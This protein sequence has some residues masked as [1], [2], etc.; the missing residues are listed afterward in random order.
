MANDTSAGNKSGSPSDESTRKQLALAR[1]QGDA[2]GKAVE[3][4]TQEEA[5]GEQV[6]TDDYLVGYAVEEAEGM[7][8]FRD[9]ALE[10]Q[11]PDDENAHIEIVVRDAHDGRFLPGLAVNVTVND[12]SGTVI[13]SHEQP[14]L[15]HPWL[16]HYG[17]NWKL[18]GD[19]TYKLAVH[20]EPPQYMRHDKVNGKRFAE[21][22]DVEFEGV[23]IETGQ[24]KS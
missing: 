11:N 23:E 5:H 13:G 15:W 9:G 22:V 3:M 8:H 21:A 7:Y 24:K 20:V 1:A 4:M 18:P 2:F 16:F 19:G 12:E 17:R 6:E 14:F 10:W